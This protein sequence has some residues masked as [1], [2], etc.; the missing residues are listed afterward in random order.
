MKQNTILLSA[1]IASIITLA[2]D[3]PTHSFTPKTEAELGK[4]L[5]FD[6]ILS[7]DRSISCGS[8]HKPEYGFAD[9]VPFSFGIDSTKTTR[10]TP[11]VKNVLARSRFFWDGRANTL[12]EQALKPIENPDEMNLP[13]SVA[14]ERL[15]NNPQYRRAFKKIFGR[16]PDSLNLA[17]AIAAYE[18][19][20][21]STYTAWDRFHNGDTKAMSASA[22]RGRELFL[23]KA[24][25]FECHFGPDFTIDEMVNIGIYDE[26]NYT[27]KGLG[28][29]TGN[30][31]DNGKFK[32]PGLRNII[33]TA[34]YMHNGMFATLRDVIEYYNNPD[35]VIP[36]AVNVDP[37]LRKPLHL[38]EQEKQDLEAFLIALSD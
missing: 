15:N 20:L 21:E 24:N 23:E 30:A 25:C 14:V 26:V 12:E 8:C 11:T 35:S 10:N 6:P 7:G 9:N 31:A 22:Q 18:R 32:V 13:I 4:Q 38:T 29:I 5:F 17:H 37:R 34:P 16:K 36:N 1:I 19:T 3:F 27:D 33:K 28:A 2:A